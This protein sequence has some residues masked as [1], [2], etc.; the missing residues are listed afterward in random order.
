MKRIILVGIAVLALT[1][2][3]GSA[4]DLQ[5]RGFIEECGVYWEPARAAEVQRAKVAV[6]IT[7][8]PEQVKSCE[9]LGIV[10]Q[11]QYKNALVDAPRSGSFSIGDQSDAMSALR[12]GTAIRNGNAA[13]YT[14]SSWEV[15]GVN[16][17][18]RK[19]VVGEAYLC[20]D[21]AA[22][23]QKPVSP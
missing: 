3:A 19:R 18:Q 12:C 17:D 22:A 11:T 21:P 15:L 10:E 13:L 6:R 16:Q 1:G 20:P 2:C 8:N 23:K 4:Y 5:R 7:T 9:L 14:S